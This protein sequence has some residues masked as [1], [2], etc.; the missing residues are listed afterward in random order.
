MEKRDVPDGSQLKSNSKNCSPWLW[1]SKYSSSTGNEEALQ[2]ARVA[3]KD[4]GDAREVEELLQAG[5]A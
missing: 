4:L 5:V 1:T 2:A 3:A